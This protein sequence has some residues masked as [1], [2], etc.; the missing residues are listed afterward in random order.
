LI[1]NLVESSKE[2]KNMEELEIAAIHTGGGDNTTRSRGSSAGE[3]ED[4]DFQQNSVSKKKV[5]NKVGHFGSHSREKLI[6][7]L[8]QNSI[9]L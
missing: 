2:K 3:T 9:I 1:D 8:L 4:D 6:V 7:S 5:R